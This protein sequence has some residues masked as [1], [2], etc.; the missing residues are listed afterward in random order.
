MR[1]PDD[2][3][4]DRQAGREDAAEAEQQHGDRG[5]DADRLRQQVTGLRPVGLAEL[6]AVADA[7]ARR[8]RDVG[9]VVYLGDVAR[10]EAGRVD[11][12]VDGG[13]GRLA[14]LGRGRR[15]QRVADRQHVRQLPDRGGGVLDGRLL[16][17][18]GA[19]G[20][21]EDQLAGL[22]SGPGN[23]RLEHGG[24]LR[25]GGVRQREVIVVGAAVRLVPDG[26]EDEDEQPG[27]DH[28]PRVAGS[29]AARA[30]QPPGRRPGVTGLRLRC[31]LPVRA[32]SASHDA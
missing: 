23:V 12:E 3:G 22:S 28:P 13:V 26:G 24:A 21:G 17:G 16:G 18:D 31:A 7:D 27:A 20:H 5:D 15:G 1:R 8:P 4:H 11:V 19:A 6:A 32:V 30:A 2:G 14:V 10:A 9:R 25:G 29:P